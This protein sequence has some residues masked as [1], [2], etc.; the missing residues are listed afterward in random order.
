LSD[1]SVPLDEKL[2]AIMERAQRS[3]GAA[4]AA[5]EEGFIEDAASRA[6]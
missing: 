4:K 3:L 2:S 5:F 1:E 6:Y